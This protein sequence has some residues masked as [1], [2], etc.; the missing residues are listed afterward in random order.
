MTSDS[1]APLVPPDIVSSLRTQQSVPNLTGNSVQPVKLFDAA[2]DAQV[3]RDIRDSAAANTWRAYRADLVDF[4][5]WVTAERADWRDPTVVADY[6]RALES[7]GAKYSTI[8]RRLT[9]I[10][11][12]VEVL[13]AIGELDATETPTKHPTVTIALQAIRRRLGTDLDQA[14]PLTAERMIQVLLAID[15][16]TRAGQRDTALLLIGWYGA[17]RRSELAAIRRDRIDIDDHG[18]AIRFPRTKASQE[19]SVVVPIAR[20]S[21]SRWCPVTILETWLDQLASV[22]TDTVWPWITKGDTYRPGVPPIGPAAIDGIVTR[23]ITAAGLAN[24]SSYSPH[25]LRS[26]FITEAKN[27]GVDEADIMRHTRLKSLRIMRSYDRESGWWRRNPTTAI[28]L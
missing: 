19:H 10:A 6:L 8:E 13:V 11:K 25:S 24:A 20:N 27:R 7:A 4:D 18:A 15:D 12:L 21:T 14:A 17:M 5:A 23:R 16:T 2:L 9:S 22:D 1:S 28:T 3:V 26:G